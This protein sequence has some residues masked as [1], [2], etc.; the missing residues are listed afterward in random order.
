MPRPP[1]TL[2]E[3]APEIVPAFETP[4]DDPK[5]E[6]SPRIWQTFDEFETEAMELTI[7]AEAL[8]PSRKA[9]LEA[10]FAE[11]GKACRSCHNSYRD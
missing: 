11:M 1:K 3:A 8:D 9:A 4:A 6:A 2:R 7:A 5:S 10:S